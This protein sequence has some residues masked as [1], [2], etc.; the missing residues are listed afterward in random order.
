MAPVTAKLIVSPEAA[1]AIAARSDP[2]PP[3]SVEVTVLVAASPRPL[4]AAAVKYKRDSRV[5]FMQWEMV[6]SLAGP[7]VSNHPICFA[8][9]AA[10]PC[11]VSIPYG[12]V[13]II[14]RVQQSAM[15]VPLHTVVRLQ[16][17]G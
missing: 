5:A 12:L 17:H 15:C 4:R 10:S 9:A 1:A 7:W 6:R 14:L 3:S 11:S 8:H 2:G 13:A 16:A